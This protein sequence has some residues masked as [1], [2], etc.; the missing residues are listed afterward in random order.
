MERKKEAK[1]GAAEQM[2]PE[3]RDPAL[4]QP[5]EDKFGRTSKKLVL[6][7]AILSTESASSQCHQNQSKQQQQIQS[8]TG[9]T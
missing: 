9:L 2:S 1:Q 4:T 5:N 8:H 6:S 3:L 7:P